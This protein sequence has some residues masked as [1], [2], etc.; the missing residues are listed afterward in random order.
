MT[1]LELPRVLGVSVVV[2]DPVDIDELRRGGRA[3]G[4][5]SMRGVVPVPL[6]PE[7]C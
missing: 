1:G 3:D 5:T 2:G 7:E 6:V 4:T